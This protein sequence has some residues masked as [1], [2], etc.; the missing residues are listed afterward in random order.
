MEKFLKKS[1]VLFLSALI[2]FLS[3][4]EAAWSTECFTQQNPKEVNEP[5]PPAD[6]AGEIFTDGNYKYRLSASGTAVITDYSGSETS[7]SIPSVIN[8]IT[9]TSVASRA[10]SSS[11]ITEVV[12][13]D[14]VQTIEADSFYYAYRITRVHISGKTTLIAVRAFCEPKNITFVCTSDSKAYSYAKENRAKIS[15]TDGQD[16]AAATVTLAKTQILQRKQYGNYEKIPLTVTLN[17]KVLQEGVDYTCIWPSW[18]EQERVGTKTVTV[19]AIDYNPNHYTGSISASYD[20]IPRASDRLCASKQITASSV[21]L[22]WAAEDS[23]DGYYLYRR[24]KDSGTFEL[25]RA[26]T[27]TQTVTY[28]DQGL[29]KDTGYQYRLIAYQK[30]DGKIYCSSPAD[31]TVYTDSGKKAVKSLKKVKMKT[32][33]IKL[34]A[35]AKTE[36]YNGNTAQPSAVSDFFDVQGRYTIAYSDKNYVYIH[37]LDNNKLTTTKTI[38]IK[39]KYELV[40]TVTGGPDGNYYIVWGQKNLSSGNVSLSASKYD[41]NGRFIKSC[42]K[43]NDGKT[44]DTAEPFRGGNCAA[45]FRDDV[46]ICY[47]AGQMNS[48]HQSSSVFSVNTKDMTINTDYYSRVSHSFDQRVQV[49]SNGDVLFADLG[50]AS[51]RGFALYEAGQAYEWKADPFHFYGSSGDNY[52]YAK[53]GGIGEVSTGIVL[54]GT[55]SAS[56]TKKFENEDE[57]LFIQIIDPISKT[58]VIGNAKRKGTSCGKPYTD[59]GIKWI[60]GKKSG[61][62]AS[63]TAVMEKDRILVMWEKDA[64]KGIESYYMVLSASGKVLQ[65]PTKIGRVRLNECE[66]IKYR[67]G[68]VYWTT[69]D[70]KKT[71]EVHKLYIGKSK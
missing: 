45:A 54:V 70:G 23:A 24:R 60:T 2:L 8:G 57:R 63:N 64:R 66:E 65:K 32:K 42:E 4:T 56:M 34:K 68:C 35:K 50:D 53:L 6:S 48:T 30:A 14:T 9:V 16:L 7:V 46:L 28:T 26:F 10:F 52:I 1:A 62:E 5:A 39:K 19:T 47:Y 40:G 12:V 69:A 27:G 25:I 20:V 41:K 51:P 44:N 11:Q 31:L 18:S 17:G 21:Q 3:L 22:K 43:F 36:N 67:N 59:T 37:I 61:V 55:S 13:P 49:L 71:A 58:S 15:L 33:K 38:K 29:Q